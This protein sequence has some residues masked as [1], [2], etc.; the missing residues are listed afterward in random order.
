[1]HH[2]AAIYD[3]IDSLAITSHAEAFDRTPFEA[4][5]AGVPIVF[6]QSGGLIEHMVPGITG[7]PYSNGNIQELANAI[8][9]L[10]LNP[11]FGLQPVKGAKDHYEN[12]RNDQI[13][14]NLLVKKLRALR[15]GHP[16]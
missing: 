14:K 7:L 1:M 9:M 10:A 15:N 4:T 5:E 3:L 16:N 6:S 8:K 2:P 13:G 12:F 11:E